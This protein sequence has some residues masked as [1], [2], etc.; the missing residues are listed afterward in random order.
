MEET[1]YNKDE[2]TRRKT[3]KEWKIKPA[4]MKK[5]QKKILETFSASGFRAM[6][7]KTQFK[8]WKK[9]LFSTLLFEL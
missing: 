2:I 7:E 3:S 8:C 9:L 1:P 4:V 6:K 5:K